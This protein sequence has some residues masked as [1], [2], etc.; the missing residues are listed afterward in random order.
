MKILGYEI[1]EFHF[2]DWNNY[3]WY[4]KGLI[5]LFSPILIPLIEISVFF[6]CTKYI[7]GVK[8]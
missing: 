2:K 6:I 5:I 3:K 8:R 7:F 1:T 4:K